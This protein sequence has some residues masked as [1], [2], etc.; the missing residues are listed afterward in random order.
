MINFYPTYSP[1][2][3][4]RVDLCINFLQKNAVHAIYLERTSFTFYPATI[5]DI[6]KQHEMLV[7]R[8]LKSHK[9]KIKP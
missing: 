6:A 4:K 2:C 3:N 8:V 7:L 5:K 1:P 9:T